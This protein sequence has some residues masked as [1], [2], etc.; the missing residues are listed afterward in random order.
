MRRD[1]GRGSPAISITRV[2]QGDFMIENKHRNSLVVYKKSNDEKF[3]I[4]IR[5]FPESEKA[6]TLWVWTDSGWSKFYESLDV[7]TRREQG[8]A[9]RENFEEDIKSITGV[10]DI[11]FS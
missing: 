6:K 1:G 7:K 9:P 2:A 10:I 11:F 8:G 3:K 4:V 5:T